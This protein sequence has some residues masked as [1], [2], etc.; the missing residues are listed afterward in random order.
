[1]AAKAAR[2][3]L[4]RTALGLTAGAT[5]A[6]SMLGAGAAS[7]SPSAATDSP[8]VPAR[9]CVT[10]ADTGAERC[11]VRYADALRDATD[12]RVDLAASRADALS[13][14]QVQRLVAKSNARADGDVI[15]AAV[16]TDERYGGSSNTLTIGSPCTKD[17]NFEW[18]LDFPEGDPF[19]KTIS[20][21]QSWGQ[22]WV[23]LFDEND[24]K[25]G[26]WEE[27][28]PSLG[29]FGDWATYIWLS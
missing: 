20:S 27:D 26:P 3:P 21:T 18:R 7:A 22:C 1:M 16:Y 11:Y 2:T 29:S 6:A 9:H 15:G 23:W 17:G 5:L 19:R 10:S 14:R 25:A 12:G 28:A 4:A 13:E 8:R 24:T